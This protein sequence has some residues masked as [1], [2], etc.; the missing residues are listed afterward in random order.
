VF[1]VE[2][3]FDSESARRLHPGQPVDVRLATEAAP[4]GKQG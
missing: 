3:V 4:A 1:M 2:A